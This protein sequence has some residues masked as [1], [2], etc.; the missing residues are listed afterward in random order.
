VAMRG[1][2]GI[3]TGATTAAVA[4]GSTVVVPLEVVVRHTKGRRNSLEKRHSSPGRW[5]SRGRVGR[6]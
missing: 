1:G 6:G 3:T 5:R 4:P 2:G